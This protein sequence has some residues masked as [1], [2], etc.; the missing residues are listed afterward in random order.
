MQGDSNAVSVRLVQS[1]LNRLFS[2]GMRNMQD[3]GP[4]S[5]S[6]GRPI[7]P[8]STVILR[9]STGFSTSFGAS[10]FRTPSLKE[11]LISDS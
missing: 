7:S 1:W 3:L 10:S 8:Y 4:A 11:A 9:R 6:P 2:Q 5:A